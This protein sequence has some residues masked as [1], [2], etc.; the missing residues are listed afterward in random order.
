MAETLETVRVVAQPYGFKVINKCDLTD[1]D[2]LYVEPTAQPVQSQQPTQTES[3]PQK[4][5]MK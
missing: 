1:A 3:Q 5:R 4:K 2:V